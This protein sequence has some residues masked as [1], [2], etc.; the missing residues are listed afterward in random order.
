MVTDIQSNLQNCFSLKTIRCVLSN[1]EKHINESRIVFR[2]IGGLFQREILQDNKAYHH[3]LQFQ[4]CFEFICE[5]LSRGYKQFNSWDQEQEYCLKIRKNGRVYFSTRLVQN[6]I[7]AE[8]QHNR[9]KNRLLQENIIVPLLVDI[10]IM[11]AKGNIVNSKYDKFR[12]INRFLEIVNDVVK[13]WD[14]VS[15]LSILDF[16]CGKSY[17]TFMLYYYFT[18]VMN[19]EVK[20][21]GVDTKFDIIEKC[22]QTALKYG[23]NHM[24]FVC[25]NV[26]QYVE[27]EPID[28]VISLHACDTATD[29]V[30]KFAVEHNVKAVF[31]VP[32]CQHELNSQIDKSSRTMFARH[33]LLKERFAALVTDAVRANLMEYCGYRTQVLEFVDFDTTAK[34][35]MLRSIKSMIPD[36]SREKALSEVENVMKE[37]GIEPTI[38]NL[39]ITSRRQKNQ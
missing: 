21:T 15:P 4:E 9:K 11:T 27:I 19:R 29:H 39:L 12:Q 16:G 25:T 30:L 7:S 18:E 13:K 2:N 31:A 35:V 26:G 3:N 23:F 22:R 34:N 17:L 1:P 32:C 6:C 5:A 28:I 36:S 37:L 20:I 38:Y 8:K 33:S 24:H 10:G 14:D